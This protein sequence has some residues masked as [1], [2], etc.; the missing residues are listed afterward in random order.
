MKWNSGRFGS[1]AISSD[2][3]LIV[4]CSYDGSIRQW[5]ARTGEQVGNDIELLGIPGEM[6]IR[7]DN[8]T[9]ACGSEYYDYVW[10][11]ETRSGEPVGEPMKWSEGEH[12]LDQIERARLCGHQV[13]DV[14]VRKETFPIEI[15]RTAVSPDQ[16]KYVIGLKIGSVVICERR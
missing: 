14:A 9:I 7:N 13:Y 8:D 2:G 16:K 3:N 10:K 12:I 1:P 4:S 6:V 5:N 11:W 15:Q